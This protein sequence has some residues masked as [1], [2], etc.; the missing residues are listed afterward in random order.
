MQ[1]IISMEKS[2]ALAR[3]ESLKNKEK[4]LVI[5]ADYGLGDA[6]ATVYLL[7]NRAAFE[8]IDIVPVGGAVP[9]AVSMQNAR[10][11]LAAAEGDGADLRGVRL[12][13]CVA[14]YQEYCMLTDVHGRDGMGDLF[15]P[16]QTAP[17]PEIG[18][19]E[20]TAQIGEGYRILS[21]G[22]CTMVKKAIAAAPHL[23][24]GRIV[25]LG[26]GDDQFACN[27]KLDHAS[28]LWTL[29]RPHVVVTLATC[30][31]P[32]FDLMGTCKNGGRLFDMLV[33]RCM[34]LAAAQNKTACCM[35]DCVAALALLHPE[36]FTES[37]TLLPEIL[38]EKTELYLKDE[39]SQKTDLG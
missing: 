25:V 19:E 7:Q 21:L 5:F 30:R 2:D 1:D 36:Y 37:N 15:A 13:D 12:V 6:C 26:D 34:E 11:L 17:V 8:K 38:R 32:A 22:P 3:M 39:Y 23:P 16:C 33:N 31:A 27:D 14:Y 35:A 29:R 24:G 28:F 9:P 18:F 10:T 4:R 20:W